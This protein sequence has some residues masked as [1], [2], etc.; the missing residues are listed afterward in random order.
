MSSK[1]QASS[2]PSTQTAPAATGS[3]FDLNMDVL[4]EMMEALSQHPPDPVR[5]QQ[6]FEAVGPRG[7]EL[8]LADATLGPA[9]R[10][11]SGGEAE[12]GG[13]WDWVASGVETAA[14]TAQ[15]A[16]DTARGA[17]GG[18]RH[19]RVPGAALPAGARPGAGMTRTFSRDLAG[20]VLGMSLACA[21]GDGNPAGAAAS[22]ASFPLDGPSLALDLQAGTHCT[23]GE[24]VLLSCGPL[25]GS[26]NS[27]AFCADDR[28]RTRFRFGRIGDPRYAF[29][30]TFT[31]HHDPGDYWEVEEGVAKVGWY[32]SGTTYGV[33]EQDGELVVTAGKED[34]GR[35]ALS[36]ARG[37]L[38]SVVPTL[39]PAGSMRAPL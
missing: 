10:A 12:S 6:L 38:S 27:L 37:S 22:T 29:P 8:A 34:V 31:D 30:P 2:R 25:G 18:R 19:L 35:C 36:D 26:L 14:S 15:G 39:K 23:T 5:C 33:A 11:L 4:D 9:M 13:W 20:V 32:D 3:R 28:G 24:T 17:V 1:Q 21:G 16:V 7:Q